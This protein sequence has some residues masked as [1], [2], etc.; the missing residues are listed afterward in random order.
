[1]SFKPSESEEDE[2]DIVIS[3]IPASSTLF[4]SKVGDP[5]DFDSVIDIMIG[6][7]AGFEK[8]SSIACE[9]SFATVSIFI[10]RKLSITSFYLLSTG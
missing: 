5:K 1:M 6:L 4:L 3:G 8:M 10:M 7:S 2:S 9:S